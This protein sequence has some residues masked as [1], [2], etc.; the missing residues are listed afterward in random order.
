MKLV[1]LPLHRRDL[2]IMSAE[3]DQT[4]ASKNSFAPVVVMFLTSLVYFGL[5]SMS[6]GPNFPPELAGMA[7][8]VSGIGLIIL[9][10]TV[11]LLG[12]KIQSKM[13]EWIA[14]FLRLEK[15]KTDDCIVSKNS[16]SDL[17]LYSSI[18]EVSPSP[19][20]LESEFV[21][22]EQV[23]FGPVFRETVLFEKSGTDPSPTGATIQDPTLAVRIRSRAR[24]GDDL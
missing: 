22:D 12:V 9:V 8:L 6:S 21:V 18:D 23:G 7:H 14:R 13:D 24:I 10:G 20:V 19:Q 1:F 16:S 4:D 11:L 5:G 17:P 15:A 2:S 3:T